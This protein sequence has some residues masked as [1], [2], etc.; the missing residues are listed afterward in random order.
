MRKYGTAFVASHV[1]Q[2]A[3]IMLEALLKIQTDSGTYMLSTINHGSYGL[4]GVDVNGQLV[5][6]PYRLIVKTEL[7][8]GETVSQLCMN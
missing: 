2:S 5:E 6:V 1:N 4:S 7:C 3:E 8:S